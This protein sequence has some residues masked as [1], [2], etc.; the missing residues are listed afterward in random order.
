VA[1]R[2]VSVALRAEV[3]SYVSGMD[4]AAKASQKVGDEV[5]GTGKRASGGMS[6]LSGAA[7]VAAA[8]GVAA[9]GAMV[10]AAAQFDSAMSAVGAAANASAGDL[11]ALR[12]A[13]LQAG[14]DTVFSAR[15][16]ANA[17]EE[18]IKAGVSVADVLGGGLAGALSLAAAGSLDV[19]KAAEI[20]ATAMTQFKLSGQDV[21]H[22]ADLLAAGAGKAQGSVDDIGQALKQSGLVASQFGLSIEDTVGSLAAFASAGLIGSDAGTSLKTMLLSLANP[23]KESADLMRQLG[24]SAYDAQG[25]FVGVTALAGQLQGALGGLTQA[26]RDQAL[27]QIFGN[28]AVRAANVLYSQGSAGIQ[29]WIGN[30]DQAGYASEQAA[31][32]MDNLKGDVEAL[33][34]SIE[35]AL[36]KAGSGANV[37][38]R[39]LAQG[40][41]GAVNAFSGMPGAVQ[42]GL[43]AILALG[44]AGAGA[45]AFFGTV[46]PKI[47][48]ARTQLD[49]MGKAGAAANTAIGRLGRGLMIGTAAFAGLT[50]GV[51]AIRKL[52]DALVDTPP[53]VEEL[54]RSLRGATSAG[55]AMQALS[56]DAGSL[57]EKFQLLANPSNVEVFNRLGA[58]ILGLQP[59]SLREAAETIGALD[60]SLSALVAGGNADEAYRQYRLITDALESQGVSMSAVTGSLPKYTAALAGSANA[61][62][63]AADGQKKVGD[64]ASGTAGGLGKGAGAAKELSEAQL[65]AAAAAG[66]LTDEML[67]QA[68]AS[69]V[70]SGAL[71]LISGNASAVMSTQI[72]FKNS[73]ADF[74][75]A[76]KENG[77]AL[78]ENT[79][80]SA[81]WNQGVRDN[82][83][84]LLGAME[85]ARR[86]AEAVT[87][88]AE[89]QGKG[90]QAVA[91]GTAAYDKSVTSIRAAAVAAGFNKQQVDGLIASVYRTPAQRGVTVTAP[92][93][94]TAAEEVGKVAENAGKV[95]PK[96]TITATA[97]TNS[98]EAALQQ[99]TRPR[100][101]VVTAEATTNSAEATMATLTRGRRSLVTAVGSATAAEQTINQAARPRV[102]RITAET[103]TTAAESR[104]STAARDRSAMISASAS[105]G[106]AESALNYLTRPRNATIYVSTV[107]S[108]STAAERGA[109]ANPPR[110]A[111]GGP[112]EAG[113]LYH[114]NESGEEGYWIPPENGYVINHEDWRALL[115]G[116]DSVGAAAF[117]DVDSQRAGPFP[118]VDAAGFKAPWPEPTFQPPWRETTFQAPFVTIGEGAVQVSVGPGADMAQVERVV[119]RAFHDFAGELEGAIGAGAAA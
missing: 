94:K 91:L 58:G 73:M 14:A 24:I 18:L 72:A 15:E 7:T 66:K 90:A 63:L 115:S 110:R 83:E 37:V 41:T 77:K 51:I 30:V 87:T 117:P 45:L 20:A 96:V 39:E 116:R 23:A 36:I 19:A 68:D 34:G 95:P 21:G 29:T 74:S 32:K 42:G 5:E 53:M 8:A 108:S 84:A 75:A 11:Q 38:L 70:L 65:A 31:A 22:I 105:T 113:R 25:N 100:K 17:Q 61:A 97:T 40:A 107:V 82:Q 69:S 50:V 1:N 46:A 79:G 27:A 47:A 71:D 89:A 109:A 81:E 93:A 78:Q 118:D 56:T 10:G 26:Q 9:F 44:T 55:M 4:Q 12:D 102:S 52:Q 59:K 6:M 92:G 16:A 112:V 103:S 57:A 86:N 33:K 28:D 62:G 13:A 88:Q 43:T 111:G 99:T 3:G 114:V 49:G 101:T 2:T 104:L 98:A 64:A 67:D 60:D 35:T 119:A 48:E 80:K 106:A 54:T 85:A 76:V